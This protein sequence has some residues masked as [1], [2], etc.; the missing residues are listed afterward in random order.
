MTFALIHISKNRDIK[1]ILNAVIYDGHE[2]WT[3]MENNRELYQLYFF[4]HLESHA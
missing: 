4:K 3:L 1:I 2:N